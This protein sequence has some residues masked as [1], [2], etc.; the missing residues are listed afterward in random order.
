MQ[1]ARDQLKQASRLGS[2]P[3]PLIRLARLE[4]EAG[5]LDAARSALLQAG[6]RNPDPREQAELDALTEKLRNSG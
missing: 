2:S 3:M 4:L 5:R 6:D 1:Q